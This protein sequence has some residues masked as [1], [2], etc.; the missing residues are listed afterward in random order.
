M[1]QLTAFQENALCT[2]KKFESFDAVFEWH[3]WVMAKFM[4]VLFLLGVPLE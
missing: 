1:N 4:S 2:S 3:Y